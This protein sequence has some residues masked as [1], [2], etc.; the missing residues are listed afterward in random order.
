VRTHLTNLN[1]DLVVVS[2]GANFDGLAY[3]DLC[4][5]SGRP[6]VIISQKATDYLWPLDKDRL[7]MRSAFQ[8]A[9]RCY[10]VSQHNLHLTECQIGETLMNAEIACNP[11]L[12]SGSPLPWP[13]NEDHSIKL[14]CVARLETGEKGQDILLQVLARK[15]WRNRNLSV[16][17]FGAGHNGEA[18]RDIAR[19][20]TLIS[21]QPFQYFRALI[22]VSFSNVGKELK[23]IQMMPSNFGNGRRFRHNRFHC[24]FVCH[25]QF[26]IKTRSGRSCL[27]SAG[28]AVTLLT[29]Q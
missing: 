22:F 26:P 13:G 7:V 6:Y 27:L 4:R 3:N 18:L 19:R 12:V 16:S 24:L 14:A 23:R 11:F 1:P 10:F 2:Q 9:L 8:S 17:F 29:S 5:I 28:P 25:S 20:L 15:L 21:T